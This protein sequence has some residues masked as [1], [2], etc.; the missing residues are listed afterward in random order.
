[1]SIKTM[2][3]HVKLLFDEFVCHLSK[4]MSIKTMLVHVK[5][6]FDEYNSFVI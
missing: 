4:T 3:V 6:L 5:L 2:L 1:M